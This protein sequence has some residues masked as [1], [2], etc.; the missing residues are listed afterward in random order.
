MTE[1]IASLNQKFA[2]LGATERLKALFEEIDEKDVLV[3]SSFGSTSVILLHMLSKLKPG[4]PVYFID[5]GYH[6]DETIAYRK[7]LEEQFNLQ[8]LD[9]RAEER[10]HRFTKNNE[11]WRLNHDLCC[12]INKVDPVNE[13]KSKYKVWVSGLLRF[14]NANRQKMEVF[15]QKQDIIKFHPILDMRQEEVALYMQIYDLPV[16]PLVQQGY[17]SIGCTHCTAKGSGRTG[18]WM[19]SSKVECGL[20]L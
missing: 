17:D 14:Q 7:Q 12:S 1:E 20:H 9:V 2:S 11:T 15:E 3:T 8:V 5:T 18:R 13:L 4:F 10:K 6:F 19:N 16:H